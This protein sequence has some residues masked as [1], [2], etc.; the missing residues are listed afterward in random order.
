MAKKSMTAGKTATKLVCPVC[1]AEFAIADHEHEAHGIVLGKDSGLGTIYMPLDK[2]GKNSKVNDRMQQLA[3]KG[4]DTSAFFSMQINGKEELVKQSGNGISIVN[5][6]VFDKIL[7]SGTIRGKH[8]FKQ[9]V[10]AQMLKYLTVRYYTNNETGFVKDKNGNYD[11]SGYQSHM[12]ARGYEDTWKVLV[13]M[14]ERQ[15]AM[16]RNGD[17]KCFKE[18][19]LWYNK[20][21]VLKMFDDY[22]T[23]L[24]AI[25]DNAR[26]RKCRGK[27]Y[28]KFQHAGRLVPGITYAG[29]FIKDTHKIFVAL[30]NWRKKIVISHTPNSLYNVVREFNTVRPMLH[31]KRSEFA[32][33]TKTGKIKFVE[34]KQCK[35]WQNAYKGYGAYFTMQN[36]ILFHD[37]Y[38]WEGDTH[39]TTERSIEKLNELAQKYMYDGYAMLGALRQF[40]LDNKF[41]IEAKQAEWRAKYRK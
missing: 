39:Y 2:P 3:D 10:M 11:L 31:L 36:M 14:L 18:D 21:L 8:L 19:N 23:Q 9:H 40:I 37:C 26:R 27:E 1:G 6:E 22:H 32:Y 41:D 25:F 20:V 17:M 5:E 28:I 13:G 16:Y 30:E 29:V 34:P 15:D 7:G 35:A 38:I 33:D 4:I 24:R 12:L